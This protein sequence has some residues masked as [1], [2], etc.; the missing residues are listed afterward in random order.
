VPLI[1][2]DLPPSTHAPAASRSP[3]LSLAPSHSRSAVARSLRAQDNLVGAVGDPN[4][5]IRSTVGSCV[6]TVVTAGGLE[7]W[8]QLIPT[9]YQMLDSP[10]LGQLEGAYGALQKICE[11]SADA[12]ALQPGQQV[13]SI[14]IPKFLSGFGSQHEV[15][16]KMALS[17]VN[18][19]VQVMAE[20]LANNLELYLKGLFALA[21][22]PSAEVRK[23][24]CQALVLLL[25][26]HLECLLPHMKQ[27]I[28]YFLISTKDSDELVALEACEFWSAICETRI[29]KEYLAEYLPRL[30]P[31]LLDGLVYT[32][33]DL[34]VLGADAEE[35][36]HV[37]DRPEDIKPHFHK[38]KVAGAAGAGE[39]GEAGAVAAANEDDEDDDDEDDDDDGLDWNLRKCSASGLDI[40][41]G[42]FQRD[43][44]P[45]LLPLLQAKLSDQRW[46][47]RE[48][49][50][51]ALGAIG[52][53]CIEHMT[54]Y[55]PQLVP[56]L[57]STLA[58]V[59]P[60]VRAISCWTLSRYAKWIV[61]TPPA[62]QYFQPLMQGLLKRVLDNNKK[63]Q[64]AACSAFA[65]VE[66]EAGA[67]LIPYIGPVLQNLMFAFT[68][69]QAKNLLIL[70]DAIGMLADAVGS[71]LCKPEFVQMLMP[72]LIGRWNQLSDDDRALFPLLEC[73]TS[74]AQ[75]LGVGFGEFAQPVFARCLVLIER[76]LKPTAPGEVPIN[77]GDGPDADFI[78]CS[79]DLIS[80]LAEG[81]GASVEGLVTSSNLV[82]LLYACMRAEQSDIRQ[83]A[84]ALIGDLA[85]SCIGVLRPA[86]GEMMP[87]LISQLNPEY[88]SVCNNAAWAV[89]EIS[90]KVRECA[91]GGARVA[92][93][94]RVCD[95]GAKGGGM[96]SVVRVRLGCKA[97]A[98][99]SPLGVAH[100]V[101]RSPCLS[102]AVLRSARGLCF[103]SGS[104]SCPRP[105]PSP[106][107]PSWRCRS[108]RRCA[109][110]PTSSLPCWCPS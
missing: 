108:V 6:T 94:R 7:S 83:S 77:G 52:E 30:I 23:R 33:F 68:K 36:E 57:I 66:E 17:C 96:R 86:L 9:L 88:V 99:P 18:Q 107:L 14:L 90:I 74:V 91:A 27:V 32:E 101:S 47:V 45:T 81:L 54:D 55:L 75:A 34:M 42:L 89:G 105:L 102:V 109:R 67:E 20:P 8:P 79:L 31:V 24:V 2:P 104:H 64:E 76:N 103:C 59:K 69:Y 73:L 29:A 50:I 63:V 85:K 70:Y 110:T 12:L 5:F 48:S 60:L 100:G 58:D 39:G 10:D 15:V 71:A 98:L 38:A 87:L 61:L 56:W 97:R 62:E 1:G 106:A 11:D 93:V 78:V 13:L 43:I 41:A 28:E 37:A 84:Y 92:L 21:V 72:P 4:T 44:L 22:D 35:D 3:A 95:V 26:V 25:D 80:G 65:S 19:F 51:L 53:G 49:A 46:E 16:R 40:L 82:P